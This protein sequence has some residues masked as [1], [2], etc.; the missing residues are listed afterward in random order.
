MKNLVVCIIFIFFHAVGICQDGVKFEDLTYEKALAKAKTENKLVFVDCYTSWCGPCKMMAKAM[1]PKKEA[2]DFFNPRFVCVKYDMEKGEGIELAKKFNVKSF[3]TFLLVRPDGTVQH[4]INGGSYKLSDFIAWVEM[5]LNE[6]TS[7]DYLTKL[8]AT[9]KMTKKQLADYHWALVYAGDKETDKVIM[10]ELSNKLTDK[11]RLQDDYWFLLK[12]SKY[13]S[14]EFDFAIKNI[15]VLRK[16]LKDQGDLDNWLFLNYKT[17]IRDY[18]SGEKYKNKDLSEI[19]KICRE[20]EVVGLKDHEQLKPSFYLAEACINKNAEP[21]VSMLENTKIRIVDDVFM[22]IR[23]L[24]DMAENI[25]DDQ[26]K[27]LV[28]VG[29]K[30][31]RMQPDEKMRKGLSGNVNKFRR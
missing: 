7:L 27:R 5:G 13:G 24:G 29:E 18:F 17:G 19:K 9:G 22:I 25:N 16:N 12:G 31:I 6:K 20:V 2:G 21:V 3:P 4:R 1:F 26:A 8:Y 28:T 10:E 11:E 30:L 15:S 14:K 23:V